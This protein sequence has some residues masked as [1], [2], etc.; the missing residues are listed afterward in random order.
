VILST[1][2]ELHG[3]TVWASIA[4]VFITAIVGW[5]FYW[6]TVRPKRFS[7]EIMSINPII[8]APDSARKSLQVLYDGDKKDSPNVVL[9]RFGNTGRK[10]I[11]PTDFDGPIRLTFDQPTLLSTSTPDVEYGFSYDLVEDMQ[12]V[13]ITPRLI[14]KGEY[15]DVQFITDGPL[16]PPQVDLRF[17]GKAQPIAVSDK[18]KNRMEWI[19]L[20]FAYTFAAVFTFVLFVAVPRDIPDWEVLLI[21][22]PILM[23]ALLAAS[24]R[25]IAMR[26]AKRW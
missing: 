24:A 23:A 12:G 16:E 20:I 7:W 10:S 11:R 1:F 6:L 26:N 18:I 5:A 21:A 4:A 19:D 13:Q 2:W 3:E 9:M 14:K 8:R 17:D 15:I 22:V 25:F